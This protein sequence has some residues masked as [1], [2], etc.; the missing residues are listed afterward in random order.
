MKV[1]R[2]NWQ[3]RGD[4]GVRVARPG[5][6]AS[7]C[8]QNQLLFNSGWSI[9][10]IAAVID[11]SKY[12]T[13]HRIVKRTRVEKV[14]LQDISDQHIRVDEQV[15]DSV[16]TYQYSYTTPYVQAPS[17]GYMVNKKY[18]CWAP[19]DVTYYGNPT[20]TVT[21]GD[22]QINTTVWYL[23]GDFCRIRHDLDFTPMFIESEYVS[24][25]SGYLILFTVDLRKD[26]D[27]PYTEEPLPLLSAGGNYGIKSESIFGENVP[28]LCSNMFSKLVQAVKT[29]ETTQSEVDYRVGW[30]TDPDADT[31]GTGG[32]DMLADF[33]YLSYH[34]GG[35]TSSGEDGGM[36]M[37]RYYYPFYSHSNAYD[38][39]TVNA[40]WTDSFQAAVEIATT[41]VVLR[42]P[43][44]SPE[45]EEI[46]I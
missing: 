2:R 32:S 19:N 1:N 3:E 24:N 10:Q 12:Q 36:Y 14:N 20:S 27:Y 17:T 6:D 28:G 40:V 8:A 23:E 15:V 16:G 37:F 34:A 41:L 30:S 33:E 38:L 43:L 11:L 26:V 35:V 39:K 42:S 44:V 25:I 45:Y 29:E 13:V 7:K 31:S 18:V 4:Y 22:Y 21:E 46:T 9:M 5:F